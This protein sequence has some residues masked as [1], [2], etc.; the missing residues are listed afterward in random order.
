MPPRFNKC[1]NFGFIIFDIGFALSLV[2]GISA[3]PG[4][5]GFAAGFLIV[6]AGCLIAGHFR[7]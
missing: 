6:G 5:I 2:G 1:Q 7:K 3:N 4:L